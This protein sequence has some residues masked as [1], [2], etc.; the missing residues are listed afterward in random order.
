MSSIFSFV[1]WSYVYLLWI[2]WLSLIPLFLLPLMPSNQRSSPTE[3]VFK[4]RSKS[5]HSIPI[6]PGINS[7]SQR[8]HH[9]PHLHWGNSP[10]AALL[11]CISSPQ[12]QQSS[13][14]RSECSSPAEW[15]PLW[16]P[17]AFRIISKWLTL[18]TTPYVMWP[19]SPSSDSSLTHLPLGS[20]L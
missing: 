7:P 17:T 14:C 10:P 19:L 11:T 3:S 9:L 6:S 15:S 1:C 20:T 8:Y 5:I 12:C 2:T 4:T 16:F 13:E 18:P